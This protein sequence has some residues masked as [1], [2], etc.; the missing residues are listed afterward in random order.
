MGKNFTPSEDYS[1]DKESGE[2]TTGVVDA[3]WYSLLRILKHQSE[4]IQEFL[5]Y[6]LDETIALTKSKIGY[7][8]RYDF[9][10]REFILNSWSKDVMKDCRIVNPETCYK[11]DNTGLWGEAVR[12]QKP[13]VVNDFESDNPLKKGYP[14]GHVTLKKYLT[15]PVSSGSRIVA[16]VGVANKESD[17]DETDVIQLQLLMEAVWR[18]VEQKQAENNERQVRI[19]LQERVKELTC[20]SLVSED[21][22]K[23][24]SLEDF[25]N[26]LIFHLKDAFSEPEYFFPVIE[27]ENKQFYAA[28][29]FINSGNYL[30][31]GIYCRQ[32]EIG[33]IK[34]FNTG[35]AKFILPEE[36]AL[37]DQVARL[38][39]QW[40]CRRQAELRLKQNEEDLY[41][42]LNS[43]GDGVIATDVK[44]RIVRMNPVAEKLTGWQFTEAY[45]K[46][47]E[48][49][50]PIV[51]A[52]TRNKV[53]NPVTKVIETGQTMG[54]ANHTILISRDGNE[55]QIAD[56]AAPILDS[57]G[58]IR[59]VVFV[60]S[61]VTARYNIT[62]ALR[63]SEEKYRQLAE[64]T[65]TVM[66]EFD[67]E[68][69]RW[70][71]VSPQVERILGWKPEE[72]TN[73]QFWVD[74]LH[75]DDMKW[76]AKYCEE[77][78]LRGENH[79]FEYR[80]LKKDGGYAWLLDEVKVAMKEGSPSKLWGSIRDIT[81]QKKFERALK[82]SQEKYRLAFK[83]SPD[84]IN[85]N[86][87]DGLFVDIND[88]F[89]RLTGYSWA[90]VEGKS[91]AD[92]NIW[93]N[94]AD[95]NKL[96]TG[97][98]LEGSVENLESG[99]R[100]KDGTIKTC[101]MSAR[102]INIDNEPHILSIT[103]DI[104][105]RK[106][107]QIFRNV[108]YRLADAVLMSENL[109]T[110]FEI[111]RK[112]LG[113]IMDT[114]NFIVAF[115]D[116][117][118]DMITAPFEK[119]EKHEM[120]E[121]PAER[122]LTGMVIRNN[123]SLLLNSNEIERMAAS[124]EIILYGSRARQW[125]GVPL[126]GKDSAKGAI[127]VQSYH[128]S[129]AYDSGSIE[130]LESVA[131]QLSFY[132]DKKSDEEKSLKLSR[133]V[134]QSPVSVVITGTDS[135]IEYV[136]PRFVELTGYTYEEVV[137]Q[138]PNILQSGE[139]DTKFYR[140]LYE[141][142]LSGKDWQ[143]EMLNKK[144]NGELFWENAVISPVMNDKGDIIN[145]I[146]IKE[147]IT[148]KKQL[149]E[150]LIIAKE[151]A[152]ESDRTKSAFLA[153]MSHEIRTPMNSIVGFS[154]LLKNDKLDEEKVNRYVEIINS[155]ADHLLGLI[156]DILDVSKI[157][158]GNIQL[159]RETIDIGELFSE[160]KKRFQSAKPGI[161]LRYSVKSPFI[162]SGD[163]LKLTQILSNLIG[164]ALKFT[165]EG[166]IEYSVKRDNGNLVFKVKDTGTGIKKEDVRKIFNRF[167]QGV[168]G[169]WMSRSGTGLGLAL[170][171]AYVEKMG[172]EVWLESK[173]GMGSTFYF[174]IP[175]LPAKT[176]GHQST[177]AE[178]TGFLTDRKVRI[179]VAEDDMI[180]FH[181]IKE[182]FSNM[183]VELIHAQN[184]KKAVDLVTGNSF[185]LILM[186]IK[187]PVMDGLEA[188]RRIKSINPGIP[189]LAISAH[190]FSDE[191]EKALQEGFDHYLTKPLNPNI[192][193]KAVKDFI[194]Q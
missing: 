87:M 14:S 141:T 166:Y 81:K 146:G 34:I 92:I 73:L 97:L 6:V 56:S 171:K 139:H 61:D 17:Y 2:H 159:S 168:H 96:M 16:V 162:F 57:Q 28:E 82:E 74:N 100:C 93:D 178:N 108:Q 152:E 176:D 51:N 59:G 72:W 64:N 121:W 111:V 4:T 187:M 31:T 107:L 125:L 90:D 43:I 165:S 37:I 38:T 129:G 55:R 12:Q 184:G 151:K 181:L 86:R 192:L 194:K 30:E 27:L 22:Q 153:N 167:V 118:R 177:A 115:Y 123:H 32:K 136:N 103:R 69:D 88:G 79:V 164:N 63:K 145:F 131:S 67:I 45:K 94:P 77:C 144:K 134:E 15:I 3:R 62:E 140:K 182:M 99:F 13:I 185:D 76:A 7:I 47:L 155:N 46:P 41:I 33:V 174:S 18:I 110:L 113:R 135:I 154:G 84:A 58:S 169:V 10:R 49:L 183:N 114:S 39:G 42:T 83:T 156:E 65:E 54:L 180:G 173:W 9:S 133:A 142:V 101:L 1:G 20:I 137:G 163:K 75:P 190:A 53:E 19:E 119:G 80:F 191:R 158:S 29:E 60:F 148:D 109:N 48:E 44:G 40:Y 143:G 5:D 11:L 89:S 102:I 175:Y 105:L 71:Y 91:S 150:E 23:D 130:F 193:F 170:A 128:D 95:R 186:D 8:Y 25:C 52:E 189:V 36:Q 26:R 35:Q 179:L 104:S 120:L 68:T 106:Q 161:E 117:K 147:D 157:E 24:L 50:F 138:N 98:K 116:E 85:I 188:T 126:R 112:E 127:I 172:G 160:L 149:I 70:T 21:M 66:W 122:S 124:G 132:L 78:T